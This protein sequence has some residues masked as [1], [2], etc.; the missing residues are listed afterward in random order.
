MPAAHELLTIAGETGEAIVSRLPSWSQS[1]NVLCLALVG[2]LIGQL[3][4]FRP[5]RRI[6]DRP[7]FRCKQS[8]AREFF[9]RRQGPRTSGR[10]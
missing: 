1:L 4:L 3:L 8:R 10:L 5:L 6:L 7:D 9:L 2:T